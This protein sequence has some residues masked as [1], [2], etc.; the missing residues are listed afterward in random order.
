MKNL[1]KYFL[2]V[3]LALPLAGFAK[4]VSLYDNPDAN[5]KAIGK[6]D[7]AA[8]VVPIFSSK[9]GKWMKVGDPR[10]GNVGWIKSDD[11]SNKDGSTSFTFTQRVIND[12]KSNDGSTIQVIQYGNPHNKLAAEQAQQYIEKLQLQQINMQRDMQSV[13]QR[14]IKEMNSVYNMDMN[15][16]GMMPMIVPV[17]IMPAQKVTAPVK[18]AQQNVPEAKVTKKNT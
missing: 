11:M 18:P 13:I 1:F 8:G 2:A 3:L 7:I 10:N 12:G 4:E 14:M 16:M 15:G 17:V 6:I 9:D 5:A